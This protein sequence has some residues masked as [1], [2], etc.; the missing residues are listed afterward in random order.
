MVLTG[1]M[2][3]IGPLIRHTITSIGDGMDNVMGCSYTTFSMPITAQS[4]TMGQVPITT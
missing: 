3:M 4:M 2:T 1:Y